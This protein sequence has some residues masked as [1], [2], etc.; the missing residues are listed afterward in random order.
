MK[1]GKSASLHRLQLRC[2][3]G[4]ISAYAARSYT[5]PPKAGFTIPE[6][7]TVVAIIVLLA[8][9]AMPA[10]ERA[11]EKGR[12]AK[13][14][15]N[16]KQLAS[17]VMLSVAE[18][19]KFP[20]MLAQATGSEGGGVDTE[21]DF[22]AK[23]ATHSCLSCPS[24]T[25][26]GV[27][28][29]NYISAYGANPTIMPLNINSSR[30]PPPLI[31]ITRPSEVILF[32]DAAQVSP[33]PRAVGWWAAWWGPASGNAA[34]ASEALTDSEIPQKG[35]WGDTSLLSFRHRG[36]ANLVFVD[37]HAQSVTNIA[38]LKQ[39]NLYWNY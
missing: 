32:A 23:Y 25:Y 9:L 17:V 2:R 11:L 4:T 3:C 35:H 39:R 31:S 14:L 7:I 10:G 29:G 1:Q 15:S 5:V 26:T 8:V 30:K 34:D 6:V 27:N 13:C 36:A 38:D 12:S 24:A 16:L 20:A 18:S 37:G 19:G 33:P 28:D 21:D 22:F